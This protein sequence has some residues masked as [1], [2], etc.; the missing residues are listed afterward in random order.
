[1]LKKNFSSNLLQFLLLQWLIDLRDKVTLPNGEQIP[2]IILANKGDVS[3]NKI[4]IHITEFCKLNGIL[5]WFITSAKENANI[6]EA[7]EVLIKQIMANHENIQANSSQD[8][9]VLKQM[10]E[11]KKWRC[12]Q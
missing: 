3:L 7:M 11:E 9:I 8:S 2:V 1:M 6:D 10:P 12:C 5:A 4:P